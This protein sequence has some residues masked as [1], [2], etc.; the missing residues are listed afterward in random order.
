MICTQKVY[1]LF[2]EN[3]GEKEFFEK[4][5]IK[6]QKRKTALKIQTKAR[7]KKKQGEKEK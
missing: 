7:K 6:Y 3:A 5:I 2:Y 1:H 4:K